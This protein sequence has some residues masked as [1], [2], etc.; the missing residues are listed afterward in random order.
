M[1]KRS[2]KQVEETLTTKTMTAAEED[3]KQVEDLIKKKI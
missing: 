1:N 2:N 3:G